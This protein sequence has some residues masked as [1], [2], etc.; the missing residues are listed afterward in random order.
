M[1]DVTDAPA[2]F[3][4]QPHGDVADEYFVRLCAECEGIV[5]G[6]E[7]ERIFERLRRTGKAPHEILKL[8]TGFIVSSISPGAT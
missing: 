3:L 7:P 5:V 1:I 4:A 2:R 8:L 6:P